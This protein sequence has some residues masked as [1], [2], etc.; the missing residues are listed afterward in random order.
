MVYYCIRCGY[1]TIH[2]N[3]MKV[4]FNMDK[5]CPMDIFIFLTREEQ[6]ELSILPIHE[7]NYDRQ[8]ILKILKMG[9]RNV[10]EYFKYKERDFKYQNY[11]KEEEEEKAN[12]K[13][14]KEKK[15]HQCLMCEKT[16][17]DKS[18]LNR[19]Q[20]YQ[21]C[22][23]TK[24][25]NKLKVE[26]DLQVVEEVKVDQEF[27]QTYQSKFDISHMCDEVRVLN[28][29]KKGK[30]FYL[31]FYW[32]YENSKNWNIFMENEKV[33]WVILYDQSNVLEK[34]L[35]MVNFDIF[36]DDLIK[37]ININIHFFLDKLKKKISMKVIFE[38]F[39]Q[40]KMEEEEMNADPISKEEFVLLIK[41][42]IVENRDHIKGLLHDSIH[43]YQ[44][45]FV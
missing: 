16:F 38:M 17:Y 27:I 41:K 31:L 30:C 7:E 32:F 40:L 5:I 37:K 39:K 21:R 19:H 35:K 26:E 1:S 3:Y 10:V 24:L 12:M 22:R 33:D 45:Y 8:N 23:I 36:L 2:K 9:P 18:G 4:H 34:K 42:R 11:L 28:I 44:I 14:K 15:V 6:Y 20:S 29:F 43:D 13:K 25:E